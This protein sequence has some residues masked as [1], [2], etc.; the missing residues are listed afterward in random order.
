MK[1]FNIISILLVLLIMSCNMGKNNSPDQSTPGRM[2]P[3]NEEITKTTNYKSSGNFDTIQKITIPNA[4]DSSIEE[5]WNLDDP[6]RRESLYANFNMSDDQIQKYE[7]AID[8]W[9]GSVQGEEAYELLSA[10]EKI[11]KEDSIL[12]SILNESQ[13]ERYKKWARANDLRG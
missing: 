1:R 11:K 13:Y 8:L 5:N 6:K 10:N 3:V 2:D 7:K 9:K 12:K 4:N